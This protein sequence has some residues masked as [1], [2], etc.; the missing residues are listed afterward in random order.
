MSGSRRNTPRLICSYPIWWWKKRQP[1]AQARRKDGAAAYVMFAPKRI[2]TSS[3]LG[4][5]IYETMR[6]HSDV[7]LEF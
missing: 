1:H 7:V 4:H 5:G 6:E 3:P 2:S